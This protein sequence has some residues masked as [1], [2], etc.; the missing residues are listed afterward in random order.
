MT[1]GLKAADVT[2]ILNKLPEPNNSLM[3]PKK[4]K[5]E[6]E[7]LPIYG[8]KENEAE[9]YS[10]YAGPM[11]QS[12][13]VIRSFERDGKGYSSSRPL[14]NTDISRRQAVEVIIKLADDAVDFIEATTSESSGSTKSGAL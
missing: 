9:Y 3:V 14:F 7:L 13:S 1:R 12:S 11:E 5:P 2:L 4:V 6:P 10:R 8:L